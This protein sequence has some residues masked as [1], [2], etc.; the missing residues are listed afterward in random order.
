MAAFL[1]VP[2]RV[3]AGQAAARLE[4]RAQF[5][6]YATYNPDPE[7]FCSDE[8]P[9]IR[10]CRHSRPAARLPAPPG[11]NRTQ[12]QPKRSPSQAVEMAESASTPPTPWAPPSAGFASTVRMPHVIGQVAMFTQI[13][14]GLKNSR[15][16]N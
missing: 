10:A 7:S 16:M 2:K 14:D 13:Q 15:N 5:K 4:A 9:K 3:R 11:G 1:V 12:D 8:R 6:E